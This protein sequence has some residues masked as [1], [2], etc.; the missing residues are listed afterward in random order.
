[1][2]QLESLLSTLGQE[3]VGDGHWKEQQFQFQ[4]VNSSENEAQKEENGTEFATSNN[5]KT[6][7]GS[8]QEDRSSTLPSVCFYGTMIKTQDSSS[9]DFAKLEGLSQTIPRSELVSTIGEMF[10]TP[11]V[12]TRLLDGWAKHLST[13]H[14]VIYTLPLKELQTRRESALDLFEESIL[15]LVYT[16]SGRILEAVSLKDADLT[17]KHILI[18]IRPEGLA[19]SIQINTMKPRWRTLMPF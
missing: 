12:A 4:G 19:N 17:S 8:S 11:P 14:P 5:A 10:V 13:Q 18:S 2:A 9:L 3:N 1:M 7:S 16:N 6:S 15:H